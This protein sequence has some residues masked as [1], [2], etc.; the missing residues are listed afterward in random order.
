M[1]HDTH[2][3]PSTA[4]DAHPPIDLPGAGD[5]L[6]W[7]GQRCEGELAEAVRLVAEVKTGSTGA[8]EVLAAWNRAETAIANADSVALWTAVP[9]D[10]L[11][12]PGLL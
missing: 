8:E 6:A 9:P 12:E 1:T 5:W 2:T 3:Q 4:T 7:V 10:A 11:L